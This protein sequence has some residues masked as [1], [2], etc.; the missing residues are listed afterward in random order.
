MAVRPGDYAAK[1]NLPSSKAHRKRV[2][3]LLDFL[4]EST[5][6]AVFYHDEANFTVNLTQGHAWM[7]VGEDHFDMRLKSG[8]GAGEIF[9]FNFSHLAD[10]SSRSWRVCLLRFHG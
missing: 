6:F 3:P 5:D 2:L 9:S 7:K 8:A 1:A 4:E 10:S